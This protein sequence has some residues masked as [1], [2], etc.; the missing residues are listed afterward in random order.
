MEYSFINLR[1]C[2]WVAIIVDFVKSF[3]FNFGSQ[4]CR[5]GSYPGFK[6]IG[7]SVGLSC[8]SWLLCQGDAA[9]FDRS[10]PITRQVTAATRCL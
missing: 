4:A 8:T 10:L 1:P 7:C 9:E 5:T 6:R 3:P 2:A